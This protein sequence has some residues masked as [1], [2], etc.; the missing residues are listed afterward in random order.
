MRNIQQALAQL[1]VISLT[2]TMGKSATDSLVIGGGCFWCL[3]AI[4]ERVD[5]VTDV[6]SGYAGGNTIDPSYKEVCAGNTGHAEVIKVTYDPSKISY[7]ALIEIFFNTHDPTTLNQ[8]GN[9]IGTQYR[10][11]LLYADKNQKKIAKDFIAQIEKGGVYDTSIVTHVEA[12]GKFYHAE[13]SHQDY[14]K[15]NPQAPYCNFVIRPKI[16]KAKKLYKNIK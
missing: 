5:G 2:F 15:S 10:S 12:L 6:V 9:D 3:E 16:D 13:I 14:Y 8:Q 4:F 11:I 7:G 1:V